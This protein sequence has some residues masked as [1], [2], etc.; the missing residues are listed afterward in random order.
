L[1]GKKVQKGGGGNDTKKAGVLE[2]SLARKGLG[3]GRG[4]DGRAISR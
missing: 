3:G 2:R 4:L 1:K